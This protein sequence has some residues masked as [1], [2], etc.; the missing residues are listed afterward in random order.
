[1]LKFLKF[2]HRVR[3]TLFFKELLNLPCCKC[4]PSQ[5]IL[6]SDRLS[7]SQRL[8]EAWRLGYESTGPPRAITSSSCKYRPSDWT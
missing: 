8:A 6:P 7:E 5:R 1:M 2:G 4:D 3:L